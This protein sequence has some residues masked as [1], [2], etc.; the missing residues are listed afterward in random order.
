[1]AATVF[2][3]KTGSK[4]YLC[5]DAS[6]FLLP[7]LLCISSCSRDAIISTK[8]KH[9]QRSPEWLKKKKKFPPEG[10]ELLSLNADGCVHARNWMD[11]W[12]M[13]TSSSWAIQTRSAFLHGTLVTA[14][15]PQEGCIYNVL[16]QLRQ[17]HPMSCLF[18]WIRYTIHNVIHVIFLE[19]W[20]RGGAVYCTRIQGIYRMH[21]FLTSASIKMTYLPRNCY[22]ATW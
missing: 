16:Q 4:A 7:F 14:Q 20:E 3:V 19:V 12:S 2:A 10:E 9:W 8:I 13:C 17:R 6:C 18:N 1:M 21:Y 11:T 22:T 5:S 15:Y